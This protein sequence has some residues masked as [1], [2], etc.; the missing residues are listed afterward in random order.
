MHI[1][2]TILAV[3]GK[4]LLFL[5]LFVLVL[6]ILLLLVPLRY[7]LQAEK[8]PAKGPEG[9]FGVS[10]LLRFIQLYGSISQDRSLLICLKVCGFTLKRIQK[11][12]GG[13]HD[14]GSD[15]EE[16]DAAIS[17]LEGVD[18][19]SSQDGGSETA[20][21]EYDGSDTAVPPDGGSDAAESSGGGPDAAESSDEGPDTAASSGGGPD[22][23]VPS[24]AAASPDEGSD[25][26]TFEFQGFDTA[27]PSDEG[28]NGTAH[29]P[30]ASVPLA[31]RIN[32]LLQKLVEKLGDAMTALW[33]GI[34]R[35]EDTLSKGASK[36]GQLERTYDKWVTGPHKAA[37]RHIFGRLRILIRHYV[38]RIV[39]GFLHF[40]TGMPDITGY[41]TGLISVILPA[42]ADAYEVTPEFHERMLDTDTMIRGH[43]RLIHVFIAAAA[44]LLD[45]NFRKL[46]RSMLR[47][48]KGGKN[49]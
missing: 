47:A 22:G 25:A 30:G 18:G 2:L 14:Q 5:L 38:P 37:V 23:S 45:K 29:G 15:P 33:D 26:A 35:A 1:I 6:L 10:W 48:R 11:G 34:Y 44:L 28:T 49:G 3:I 21:F 4:V 8:H 32:D 16:A 19:A 39:K 27:V 9:R 20:A 43:I 24:D 36:A 42:G 40:G 13:G 31:E 41:L 7:E 12:G 17:E 46:L